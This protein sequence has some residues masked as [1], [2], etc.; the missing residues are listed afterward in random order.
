MSKVSPIAAYLTANKAISKRTGNVW[1]F[2][3]KEGLCLGRQIK[4]EQPSANAYL[5]EIYGSGMKKIY[6]ECKVVGQHCIYCTDEK[7]LLGISVLPD[8]SYILTHTFDYIKNTIHSKQIEK[9]LC[10]K[11]LLR[12]MEENL[13]IGIYDV[14]KP[15]IYQDYIVSE[16][17]TDM[18]RFQ[19]II[20][21][22][23]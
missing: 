16:K 20:H 11:T 19:R 23:N 9:K 7:A 17:T 3:N 4:I 13:N 12:A 22:I 10:S 8:Y 6:Y 18:P 15:L 21:D 14:E 2:Y 5:R 1:R